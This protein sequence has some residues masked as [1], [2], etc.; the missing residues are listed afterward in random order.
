VDLL[1]TETKCTISHSSQHQERYHFPKLE[2]VHRR[3]Q[4]QTRNKQNKLTNNKTCMECIME[5]LNSNCG[6]NHFDPKQSG[7]AV[8]F[9]H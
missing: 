3:I 4:I 6:M 5:H 8:C 1:P 2:L 9:L 7:T